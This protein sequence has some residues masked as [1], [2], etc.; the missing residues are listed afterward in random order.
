[1]IKKGLVLLFI[2]VVVVSVFKFGILS[3][4]PM[5]YVSNAIKTVF[6]NLK[7]GIASAIN[8]HFGQ[9]ETIKELKIENEELRMRVAMLGGFA[10]EV[11]ELGNFKKYE[12]EYEPNLSAVRVI[13]YAQLPYFQ[14]VWVDFE[15]YNSSRIYGLLYNNATAGIISDG[16]EGNALAL[17]NGDPKCSY[18]VY[19][20]KKKAPGIVMGKNDRE[21]V[22]R[23]IPSWMSIEIGDEV[24]TS[25]L[26][27]IFFAGVKVGVVTDVKTVHAYKEAVIKP[28]FNSLN[29][30]YFYVIEK[31]R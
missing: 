31:T 23:Y 29:P 12:K 8:L 10:N 11:V 21:M 3:Q 1:M 22:V 7:E 20:G 18:A 6:I 28:Y 5:L 19:V 9:A 26:D 30:R 14:K 27:G 15:D 4:T 13:S 2:L 25:G 16:E 24:M 17:L